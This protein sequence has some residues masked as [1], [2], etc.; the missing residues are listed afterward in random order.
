MVISVL[1][2]NSWLNSRLLD[3][4]CQDFTYFRA[5]KLVCHSFMDADQRTGDSWIRDK[6]FITLISSGNTNFTFTPVL[7]VSQVPSV[8]FSSIIQSCPTLCDSINCSTPG[9]LVHHQ[10]LEL[11]KTHVHGVSNTI[12]PAHPPLSSVVQLILLL[13]SIF[14][15]IRVF[16]KESVL[17]IR[18]QSTEASASASAL[19][20]NIQNWFVLGLTGLTSCQSKWLSGVFSNTTVQKHQFFGTQLSL[21]SNSHIHTW[22]LKKT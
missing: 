17:H 2:L 6:G 19:P 1:F 4:H 20:V 10:L 7:L 3:W 18:W 5:N 16:S 9:F 15:S 12:Q 13:P 14:P 22:L 21:W 8:Q 11:A